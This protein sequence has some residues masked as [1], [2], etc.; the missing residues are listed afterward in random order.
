MVLGLGH[1]I[2]RKSQVSEWVLMIHLILIFQAMPNANTA[3][4]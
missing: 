1:L 3:L 4:Q 2:P